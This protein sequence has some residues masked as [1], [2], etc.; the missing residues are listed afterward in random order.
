MKYCNRTCQ[1]KD[2][3]RRHYGDVFYGSYYGNEIDTKW[4]TANSAKGANASMIHNIV[5]IPVLS[6][7]HLDMMKFIESKMREY[8]NA[9]IKCIS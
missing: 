6:R 2:E 7:I 4:R 9:R 8:A 5:D 1:R 3:N